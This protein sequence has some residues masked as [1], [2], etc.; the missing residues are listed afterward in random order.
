[1]TETLLL[2][3]ATKI[4]DI[5]KT[6]HYKILKALNL[7]KKAQLYSLPF[8]YGLFVV[9]KKD[10]G[11]I[12]PP[13]INKK[14]HKLCKSNYNKLYKVLTLL[15]YEGYIVRFTLTPKGKLT[16]SW[17]DDLA[18]LPAFEYMKRLHEKYDLSTFNETCPRTMKE[19][20]QQ[21]RSDRTAVKQPWCD[22]QPEHSKHEHGISGEDYEYARKH[23]LKISRLPGNYVEGIK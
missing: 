18:D 15:S 17:S 11:K 5:E 13:Y 2:W 8:A 16:I 14:A 23:N 7:V 9:Y 1:M 20:A 22:G 21:D 10:N 6:P 3:G 19:V 4:I 12:I